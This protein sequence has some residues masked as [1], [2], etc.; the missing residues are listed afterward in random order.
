M[1]KTYCDDNFAFSL[2]RMHCD[3]VHTS[4]EK[5]IKSLEKIFEKVLGEKKENELSDMVKCEVSFC[6]GGGGFSLIILFGALL[7]RFWN[8]EN[9][10]VYVSQQACHL[11]RVS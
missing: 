1:M 8:L 6:R 7:G 9:V 3:E 10:Y 11:Y 5:E 4:Y 2:Y